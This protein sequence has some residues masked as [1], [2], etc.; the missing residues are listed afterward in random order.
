MLPLLVLLLLCIY[1][2]LMARYAKG[3]KALPAQ[4]PGTEHPRSLIS[5]VIAARNEEKTLPPLLR[6]LAAQDYPPSLFEVL[7]VD[8]FSTDRTADVVRE[9]Q[10]SPFRLL[11][12][13]DPKGSKK[14]AI[15]AG[16]RAARG[17]FIVITDADCTVPPQWLRTLESA[18]WQTGACFL[19]A[20]VKF[21]HDGS[22]LQRFQ[23]LD[24]LML[25]GITAATVQLRLGALCNGANLAYTKAAFESVNGFA[26]IDRVAT[27]DDLLLMHKIW[28]RHPDGIRY[29][30]SRDA[31]VVTDP[32]PGWKE[33][34]MQRRRWGSKTLV[35]EDWRLVA[36]LG[37]VFLLNLAFVALLA[38][39]WTGLP[40][41]LSLLLL[42]LGKALAE[43]LFLRPVAR[44]YG[45]AALL[46]GLFLYQP[47]HALYTVGVGL[48]SQWGRY[49]WKGRRTK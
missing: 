29:V 36:V 42:W 47:L 31:I 11:Q 20:P 4:L 44:F 1:G 32:M 2:G 5:V 18:H 21:T 27:G 49:E 15:E 40:A 12:P 23:A 6:Q 33:F 9:A 14:K 34:F 8:D 10:G 17:S 22:L 39:C 3:W 13:A 28:K 48:W 43:W 19:A 38:A 35:Y 24:F 16:V 46:P 26:G 7:V 37:F 30:K 45:E 25:Q 41:L